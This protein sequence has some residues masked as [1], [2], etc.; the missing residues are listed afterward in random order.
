MAYYIILQHNAISW[1][2][3]LCYYSIA[4]YIILYYMLVYYSTVYYICRRSAWEESSWLP[5]GT[6]RATSVSVRLPHLQK[7]LRTGSPSRDIANFPPEL[8]RRRRGAFAEVAR[9]VPLPGARDWG[10]G[11]PSSHRT[12]RRW[13]GVHHTIPYHT[14]LSHTTLYY[15]TITPYHDNNTYE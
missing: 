7:D 1:Y 11:L 4:Y 9:L 14:M 6:K 8:C 13:G 15:H 2:T 10:V 3:V 5:E 12:S